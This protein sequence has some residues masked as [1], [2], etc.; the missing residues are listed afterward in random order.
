MGRIK[1]AAQRKA[2]ARLGAATLGELAVSRVGVFCQ[3][4]RCGHTAVLEI[5][6]LLED[7]GPAF[8]VPEV[9]GRLRCTGC[10]GKDIATHPAR[11]DQS[12]NKPL[13]EARG[14]ETAASAQPVQTPAM[15]MPAAPAR[16]G[17]H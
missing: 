4:N 8:P 12:R 15:P 17:R 7:L 10:N 1:E 14:V 2:D 6:R 5:G 16:G 9:G 13:P 3:C 11:P